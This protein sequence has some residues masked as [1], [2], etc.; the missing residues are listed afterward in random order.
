MTDITK[1]IWQPD[2]Q[3]VP[4]HLFK[5]EPT[6]A[7]LEL[8]IAGKNVSRSLETIQVKNNS[9]FVVFHDNEGGASPASVPVEAKNSEKTKE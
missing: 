8:P 1:T 7:K 2:E 9:N 4:D 6:I 5:T 3:S